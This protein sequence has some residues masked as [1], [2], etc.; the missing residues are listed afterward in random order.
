[1]LQT[2]LPKRCRKKCLKSCKQ[3]FPK[4]CKHICLKGGKQSCLK[5]CKQICQKVAKEISSRLQ[6]YLSRRLQTNFSKMLQ[7]ICLEWWKKNC[8]KSCNQICQKVA[9]NVF[10]V[11]NYF[12]FKVA[13]NGATK[14]KRTR[15]FWTARM[16]T[17][18]TLN[19]SLITWLLR[20]P[21]VNF[22]ARSISIFFLK[23]IFGDSAFYAGTHQRVKEIMII[24]LIE[25]IIMIIIAE[26]KEEL[27]RYDI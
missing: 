6:T 21:N 18:P 13:S 23:H 17:E 16:R 3:I 11:A 27:K 5:R 9:K 24:I 10:K 7:Q 15:L 8:L 19:Q 12:V 25:M 4:C 22:I 20:V 1:M 14:Q 26:H 2:N